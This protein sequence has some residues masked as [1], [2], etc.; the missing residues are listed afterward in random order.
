MTADP[1]NSISDRPLRILQV[2]E[3]T[4]GGVGRHT[5]DLSLSLLDMG[6]EV[7]VVYSIARINER[8]R[9]GLDQIQSKGGKTI[10]LE[11]LSGIGVQ[12]VSA[13]K[14]LRKLLSDKPAHDILH[15]QSSKAGAVGRLARI[16]RS[17]IT[18]YTPHLLRTAS[19]GLGKFAKSAFAFAERTLARLTDRIIAVSQFEY[20]HALGI[21]LP[22]EKLR[23]INIGSDPQPFEDRT[24]LLESFQIDQD[25]IVIGF[26]GRLALQKNPTLLIEAFNACKYKSKAQLVMI[27]S[28][29]LQGECETIVR[30]L[31]LESIV[32]FIGDVEGHSWLGAFDIFALSSASES[33]PYVVLE[34]A[35]VGKP[36][37]STNVGSIPEFLVSEVNGLI[38]PCGDVEAFANALDRLIESKV[39]RKKLGDAALMVSKEYTIQKMVD[40]NLEVYREALSART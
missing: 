1:E 26:I 29:P 36:I 24:K 2:I 19:P 15:L 21:G 9:E 23:L 18:V 27:G 37:L 35:S 33:F 28:G 12:D 16:G 13:A 3:A 7:D 4:S 31:H 5:L 32:S 10:H 30:Q 20:D 22:K 6:H 25:K 38:V 11:I 8:F 40:K 34:A 14:K 17:Q 39:L